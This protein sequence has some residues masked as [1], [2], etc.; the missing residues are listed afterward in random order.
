M[1]AAPPDAPEK[2]WL[3]L[4]SVAL[5]APAE[6]MAWSATE[7]VLAVCGERGLALLPETILRRKMVGDW[8]LLQL[9]P[10]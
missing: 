5:A 4:P 7:S 10:T 2:A 9:S 3:P 1:G 8:A 6:V